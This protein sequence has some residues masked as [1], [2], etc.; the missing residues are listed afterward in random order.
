MALIELTLE[1]KI[2]KVKKAISRIQAYAF[3]VPVLPSRGKERKMREILYRGKRKDNDE[4][5][6]G[7]YCRCGWTGMEKYVIIPNYASTLYGID[8][9]PETVGQYTEL[10]DKNGKK[11]FEGDIVRY[12]EK[13]HIVVFE[14]RGGTGYFGIKIDHIETWN[15]CLSVPAKLMEVIGNIHDN[16]EFLEK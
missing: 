10:T 2:D 4:W 14:T 3:D 11:I 8:V 5:V 6:Y 13:K 1:G 12:D 7:Y 15:F 9:I 16:P